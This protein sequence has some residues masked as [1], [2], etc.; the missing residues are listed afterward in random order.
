MFYFSGYGSNTLSGMSKTSFDP[1]GHLRQA[2]KQIYECERIYSKPSKVIF[3]ANVSYTKIKTINFK[4][5]VT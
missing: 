3:S 5:P 1:H 4:N 2:G